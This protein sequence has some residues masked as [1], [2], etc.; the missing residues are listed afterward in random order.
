M[1]A[2]PTT[3]PLQ[4]GGGDDGALVLQWVTSP[5]AMYLDA[6]DPVFALRHLDSRLD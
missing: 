4:F 2:F 5:E 3:P 1:P 6:D